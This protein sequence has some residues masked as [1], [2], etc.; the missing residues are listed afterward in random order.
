MEKYYNIQLAARSY[1]QSIT[2]LLRTIWI[3][4]PSLSVM[5]IYSPHLIAN[6]EFSHLAFPDNYNR[7]FIYHGKN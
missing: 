7:L 2:C 5:N 3:Q 6:T 1:Q 4:K